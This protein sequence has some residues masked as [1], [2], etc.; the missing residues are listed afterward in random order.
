MTSKPITEEEF[1]ANVLAPAHRI[2]VPSSTPENPT[3]NGS[4][5]CGFVSYKVNLHLLN[6]NPMSGAIVTRCNCTI[7]VKAGL[8]SIAPAPVSSFAL[9]SPAGDRSELKDYKYP[10]DDLH[11]WLCPRCGVQVFSEGL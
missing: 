4:C 3:Y 11:Q 10:H 6:P 8:L 2:P 9:M 7:C 1:F 5:H